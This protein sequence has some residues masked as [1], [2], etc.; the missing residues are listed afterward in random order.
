MPGTRSRRA[1]GSTRRPRRQR[2]SI[3]SIF[4]DSRIGKISR[5][6]KAGQDVH[7][8]PPG[9]VMVVEF[10]IEGQTFTRLNGGPNFKFSEAISLQVRCE[11]QAEVDY[12][13]DKAH[14]RRPGGPLRLAE[15]Q[16]RPVM[17]SR[18]GRHTENDDRPGSREIR[19][20]H[21][22]FSENEETR[23]RGDRARLCGAATM[24]ATAKTA[25]YGEASGNPH[26]RVR[27]AA[28]AGVEGLDRSEDDGAVVRAARLHQLRC[29]ELDVRVG[30][31]FAHRDA[32][33]RRQ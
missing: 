32:R 6:T 22:R 17:A 24:T 28:R 4:K 13:W 11:T 23:Y 7:H 2:S 9:S 18:A 16:I 30:G 12:F 19:T 15:G 25:P 26:S 1:C 21:E 31:S 14:A 10:E 27:C 3:A 29:C 8:K 33:A 5:Y 20:R